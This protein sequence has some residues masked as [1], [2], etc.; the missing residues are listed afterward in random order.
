MVIY[1]ANESRIYYVYV[2]DVYIY[3]YIYIYIYVFFNGLSSFFWGDQ[4]LS[5][6]GM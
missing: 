5:K 1:I 6:A 3:V 2:W 4:L